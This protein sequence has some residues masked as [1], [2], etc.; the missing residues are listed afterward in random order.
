MT[1]D[2]NMPIKKL[3]ERIAREPYVE[4]VTARGYGGIKLDIEISIPTDRSAYTSG[5]WMCGPESIDNVWHVHRD[6]FNRQRMARF[7]T[8]ASWR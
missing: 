6:R 7:M 8:R 5:A 1:D 3:F 4:K 2:E